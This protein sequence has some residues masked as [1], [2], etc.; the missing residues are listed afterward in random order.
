MVTKKE[1]GHEGDSN[2][3]S[4]WHC[5]DQGLCS[6]W[7]CCFSLKLIFSVSGCYSFI[8]RHCLDKKAK[9]C[10]FWPLGWDQFPFD[11]SSYFYTFMEPGNR[12][13]GLNSASLCSL[14][15]RYGNPF[16][17]R[18]LS[19]MDCLKI[20]ALNIH[21]ANTVVLEEITRQRQYIGADVFISW[22]GTAEQVCRVFT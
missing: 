18:F 14:A 15:G 2:S 6:V 11:L 9:R 10:E 20:P 5:G 3:A 22:I 21:N 1:G 12:F 4:V 17:S 8:N 13:Q 19:P 7:T 16:P